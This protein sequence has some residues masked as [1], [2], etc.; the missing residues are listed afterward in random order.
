MY[1]AHAGEVYGAERGFAFFR[2]DHSR[3]A[4][5][6]GTQVQGYPAGT[7]DVVQ[8]PQIEVV[9]LVLRTTICYPKRTGAQMFPH[10]KGGGSKWQTNRRKTASWMTTGVIT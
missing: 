10:E 5:E 7:P 8:G 9:G 4:Q 2:D 6:V 3:C 1:R